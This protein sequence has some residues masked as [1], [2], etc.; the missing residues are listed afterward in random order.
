MIRRQSDQRG[1]RGSDLH[2]RPSLSGVP[3]DGAAEAKP[4]PKKGNVSLLSEGFAFIGQTRLRRMPA[5]LKH[6]DLL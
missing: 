4:A 1:H 2:H 6:S 5:F 3:H